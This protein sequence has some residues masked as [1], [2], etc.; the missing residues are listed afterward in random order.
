MENVVDD[1]NEANRF[2]GMSLVCMTCNHSPK[3]THKHT[4]SETAQRV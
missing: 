2:T 1:L 3:H 4:H